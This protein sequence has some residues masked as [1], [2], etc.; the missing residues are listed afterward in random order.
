MT[1]DADGLTIVIPTHNRFEKLSQ[2]LLTIKDAAPDSLRETIVVDDSDSPGPPLA[3]PGGLRVR[4]V[5]LGKRAYV[6]RAKNIGWRL[7]GTEYIFFIDD[8]NLVDASTFSPLCADFKSCPEAAAFVPSVLY[9]RNRQL[10]WVY[11][12]PF[13]H[14]RWSHQ[15]IGR[16]EPRNPLV[17]GRLAD[18]DALPNASLIRRSAL[19]SVG[20]F[21]EGLRTNSSADLCFRLKLSGW[22]VLAHTGSFIYHDVELPTGKSYW[23][24]HA[25]EDP[26]RVMYEISDWFALMHCLHPD[27]YLFRVRAMLHALRFM[28]PNSAAYL[29]NGET[30]RWPLML[31]M[32]QG[33]VSGLRGAGN[34]PEHGDTETSS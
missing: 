25:L 8:D 1:V 2:L 31:K 5:R 13:R 26:E 32:V 12:T 22:R 29:A 20:G 10:V 17:E 9:S 4:H 19:Q 18:T 11:A 23:A 34:V 14:G 15:L 24:R 16:N 21:L 3:R 7:A 6:S 33:L 28:L 30:H 27:A